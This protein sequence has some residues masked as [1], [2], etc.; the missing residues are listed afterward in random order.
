MSCTPG[1]P[2]FRLLDPRVGWDPASV[3]GLVSLDAE[4]AVRLAPLAG[5]P[6]EDPAAV[7]GVF[8][9]RRLTKGCGPCEWYLL[10]PGPHPVVLRLGCA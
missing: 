2:T 1:Q 8:G 3:E 4:S 5:V 7:A 10:A 6:G 9:D